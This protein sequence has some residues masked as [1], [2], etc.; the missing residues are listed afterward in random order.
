M[1]FAGPA[2]KLLFGRGAF[3]IQAIS[4]TT[5]ALFYYSIGMLGFALRDILSMA[6]YSIQDTKTPMIN[7]TIAIFLN[8]ILN[9]ILSK[10]M[11]IGGLALATS[12]STIFCTIL[13]SI[14][15]KKKIGH[16]YMESIKASTTKFFSCITSNGNYRQTILQDFI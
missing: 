4:M 16:F 15:F 3:G 11:G 2:V 7:S 14:S 5:T 6:F 1:I 13:L 9:L 10:H 12:I 8:I